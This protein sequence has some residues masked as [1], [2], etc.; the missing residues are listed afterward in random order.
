[1][2]S[3]NYS[4]EFLSKELDCENSNNKSE[5]KQFSNEYFSIN[6]PKDFKQRNDKNGFS[7]NHILPTDS[8]FKGLLPNIGVNTRLDTTSLSKIYNTDLE[9]FYSSESVKIIDKGEFKNNNS[10]YL[11][12]SMETTDKYKWQAQRGIRFYTKK[13]NRLFKFSILELTGENSIC[14]SLSYFYTLELK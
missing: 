11:W 8:S 13:D 2:F 4:N 14:N 1:M 5:S 10:I 7:I 6:F 9:Q 12:Y 3:C